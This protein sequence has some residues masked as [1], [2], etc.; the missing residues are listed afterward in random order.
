[1]VMIYVWLAVVCVSAI[2]EALTLQMAGIWF[3]VGGFVA[4]IMAAVDVPLEWQIITCIIVSL[5]L[6]LSLRRLCL[7]FLLK[8]DNAKTN[9][10]ALVGSKVKLLE[11]VQNGESTARI[12]D[13]VWSVVIQDEQALKQGTTVIVDEVQGNKLVARAL[14]GVEQEIEK[15]GDIK[16][17]GDV[18]VP[19]E[20]TATVEIERTTADIE[21]A[22]DT[23]EI[24][25]PVTETENMTEQKE[26]KRAD[27]KNKPSTK[28]K[29]QTTAT[30]SKSS[31]K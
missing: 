8:K 2:V 21:N 12:G 29:K 4:L 18:T 31:K 22:T 10:D 14:S 16:V 7:R 30:K 5:V 6:L 17:D 15:S 28:T 23:A 24:K 27:T 20:D 3:V 1:M 26:T 19:A 25:V 13:V 11:D 9:V